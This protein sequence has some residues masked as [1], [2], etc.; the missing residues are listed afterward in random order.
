M[1]GNRLR[2]AMGFALL[3]FAVSLGVVGGQEKVDPSLRTLLGA[4]PETTEMTLPSVNLGPPASVEIREGNA[5]S[6]PLIGL[7]VKTRNRSDAESLREL[8]I[9]ASTGTVHSIWATMEDLIA[10]AEDMDVVYVEP[11]RK[12]NVMVDKSVPAIGASMLHAIK[13]PIRGAGVVFGAVD[14]GIDYAHLDFRYD[15]DGDGFEESSRILSIWDQTLGGVAGRHYSQQDVERDLAL[16]L[17]WSEGLVRHRDPEGHGTHVAGIAAGDGSSS[18]Y[19]LVGVAPDA[20]IVAVR[21]SFHSANILSGIQYVFDIAERE[22]L[23]AVVNLSLGGHDG[24]HDGTSV[25]EQGIAELADAPGRAIVVSAGNEANKAIHWSMPM[26]EGSG[27]FRVIAGD[28][29]TELCMW[30]P[31]GEEIELVITSPGGDVVRVP[32]ASVT[33][34]REL[35]GGI[36]YVD[37]ASEGNS[38]LNGDCEVYLR[39]VD[40]LEDAIWTIDVTSDQAET[41]NVDAWIYSGD[42]TLDPSTSNCTIA[43]PGNARNVITV[44]ATITRAWWRSLAGWQD[45]RSVYEVGCIPTYSSMGP[46][47]DGRVKPDLVAPGTWIAAAKSEATS[48][49]DEYIHPDETH[50]YDSGTSMSAAHVSG[51][52]ALLL[53]L[54]PL[55]FPDEIT[56][57]LISTATTDPSIGASPPA[58]SGWGKLDIWAAAREAGYVDQGGDDPNSALVRVDLRDPLVNSTA[59]FVFFYPIESVRSAILRIFDISGRLAFE[60]DVGGRSTYVWDLILPRGEPAP[61]GLYFYLLATD[62]GLSQVGRMVIQ[63]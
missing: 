51:A 26:S 21:T 24:P 49:R 45:F 25:L 52:V 42:A 35:E 47:R 31:G 7:L 28:M 27:E 10:L 59:E 46:T 20:W 11:S 62:R 29:E 6:V 53:S 30:Y 16:G 12:V 54:D 14:T 39:I 41:G 37:H 57:L 50:A 44:G 3:V 5:G 58:K 13:P 2:G 48:L 56:E 4:A 38:I 1:S 23:P 40:S 36:L 22:G 17:D 60:A 8:T 43:E 18:P 19:G 9:R 55:L 34:V 63:R 61:S 32:Y 15:A 33:G